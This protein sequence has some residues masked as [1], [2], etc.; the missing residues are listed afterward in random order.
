MEQILNKI[1]S[2]IHNAYSHAYTDK[3]MVMELRLKFELIGHSITLVLPYN[4][5]A[6]SAQRKPI[7]S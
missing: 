3:Y 5:F 7:S 2:A 1:R 4:H 6:A